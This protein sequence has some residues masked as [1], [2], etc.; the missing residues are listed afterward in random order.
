MTIRKRGRTAIGALC[1]CGLLAGAADASAKAFTASATAGPLSR[2]KQQQLDFDAFFPGKITV[3][4]GDSVSWAIHG[5]HAIDFLAPGQSVPSLIMP[6]PTMPISGQTDAAGMAFWFNGLPNI[7]INPQA[8]FPSGGNVVTGSA[9]VGSGLPA[10]G[11]SNPPFKVKFAKLGSF[12]YYCPVHPGMVGVVKVVA[13]GKKIPTSAQNK[14][15]AKAEQK[16]DIAAALKLAKAKIPANEVHAGSDKGAVAWLR[17]FPASLTVKAGT[18]VKFSVASKTEVHTVTVGPA[19]YDSAIEQG[20]TQVIPSPSGPPTILLN[21]LGAYPS[22]PPPLPAFT[23]TNHGNGFLNSGVLGG[24]APG[25][26]TTSIKFATP[27]TYHYE[28]V[29]HQGMDGTIVV[30]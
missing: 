10:N 23:G 25:G 13:G 18:T 4:T 12:K 15:T 19:A 1:V 5:F 26:T 30:T 16:K 21:P 14:A 2:V 29:I 11:P 3:H 27:G 9:F 22:D 20:F 17:F 28:C 24:I 7:Q 6:R 8:A